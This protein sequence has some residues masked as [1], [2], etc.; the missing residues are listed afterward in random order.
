MIETLLPSAKP[1]TQPSTIPTADSTPTQDKAFPSV[2]PTA[3]PSLSP[4]DKVTLNPTLSPSLSPSHNPTS[5]PSYAGWTTKIAEDFIDRYGV[6]APGGENVRWTS[7]RLGRLGLVMFHS[8]KD[9]PTVKSSLVSQKV[10]FDAPYRECGV[11]ISFYANGHLGDVRN[12]T[13][14]DGFC[15][16]YASNLASG[17]TELKCWRINRDF[18]TE[19]WYD[20]EQIQFSFDSDHTIDFIRIRLRSD[21]DDRLDRIFLDK[22]DLLLSIGKE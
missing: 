7:E 5:S 2:S 14:N 10:I 21:S 12:G 4:S 17:W 8:G 1:T 18:E 20:E 16:D 19:Q 6:F 9:T 11:F 13:G 15:F 3:N 22:V